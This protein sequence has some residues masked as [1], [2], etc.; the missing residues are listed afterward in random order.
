V[1]HA[2]PV[3]TFGLALAEAMACGRPVVAVAGA[4]L[5]EVLGD[6]G[7]LTSDDPEQYALALAELLA[8]P[9]RRS[10]LGSAARR[11]AIE[12][13]SLERMGREY[14]AALEEANEK[15]PGR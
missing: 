1:V 10:A 4:A 9:P 13:F 7:V 5:G 8:D 3:E 6:A 14:A 12:L 11:R 15:P 2:C